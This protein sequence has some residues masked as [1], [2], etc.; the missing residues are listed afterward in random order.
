M[1]K[2]FGIDC[3]AHYATDSYQ[4]EC[5]INFTLDWSRASLGEAASFFG[6]SR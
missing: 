3:T 6:D 2:A 4:R 5:V 1:Q